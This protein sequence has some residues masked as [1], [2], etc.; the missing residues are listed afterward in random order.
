MQ[1]GCGMPLENRTKCP[2]LNGF[3]HNLDEKSQTFEATNIR[4]SRQKSGFRMVGFQIPTV[5]SE[6]VPFHNQTVVPNNFGIRIQKSDLLT[7]N[8]LNDLQFSFSR[9]CLRSETSPKFPSLSTRGSSNLPSLEL[10][11]NFCSLTDIF[12]VSTSIVDFNFIFIS[13]RHVHSNGLV[14]SPFLHTFCVNQVAR[15]SYFPPLGARSN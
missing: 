1:A 2:V 11:N 8:H 15:Y 14:L 4:K 9:S 5:L 12:Y 3:N 6:T 13:G 7:R 10:E